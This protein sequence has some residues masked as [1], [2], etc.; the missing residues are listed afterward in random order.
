M[1][2]WVFYVIDVINTIKVLLWVAAPICFGI[3][4]VSTI[5]FFEQMSYKDVDECAEIKGVWKKSICAILMLVTIIIFL[6]SRETMVMMAV[7]YTNC[8]EEQIY[9]V[10]SVAQAVIE[11]ELI[12]VRQR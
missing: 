2:P 5:A 12:R 7:A 4:V 3:F 8:D 6:P 11:K 9:Q 10:E 1:S